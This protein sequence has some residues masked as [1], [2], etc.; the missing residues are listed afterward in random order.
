VKKEDSV[1]WVD[2]EGSMVVQ[3]QV[4]PQYV[5]LV[6]ALGSG[7]WHRGVVL[8]IG[9]AHARLHLGSLHFARSPHE[10]SSVLPKFQAKG[11][12]SVIWVDPEG[13][14][15]VQEQVD[16]RCVGASW[17][18]GRVPDSRVHRLLQPVLAAKGWGSSFWV[19]LEKAWKCRTKSIDRTVAL[20]STGAGC[21]CSPDAGTWVRCCRLGC[22]C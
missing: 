5:G 12:D 7:C 16:P 11:E 20:A 1:I 3:D 22:S 14:M 18:R 13:S 4:D 10:H 21:G 9:L 8:S 6:L 17:H 2:P 15:A 19:D